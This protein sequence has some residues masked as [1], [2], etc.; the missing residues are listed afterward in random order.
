M[1]ESCIK[2]G[3][4]IE[5]TLEELDADGEWT[6]LPHFGVINDSK[7]T[8]V[9]MVITGD[10][11]DAGRYSTNDWLL[12]GP[13]VILLIPTTLTHIRAK[14]QF[15]VTDISKAFFQIQLSEEDRKLLVFL[16]LVKQPGGS[17]LH[18]F[19]RF[20]K[21]PLGISCSP[22][23]LN[24][25]LR[26]LFREHAEKY[27]EDKPLMQEFEDC[28]YL[29]EVAITREEDQ[30]T[31]GKTQ[32]LKNVVA[33]AFFRVTKFKSYPPR[34]T[35]EFCLE[36]K[37]KP[38]KILGL[39]FNPVDDCF[40]IKAR[41]LQEFRHKKLIT[42]K[43]AASILARPFDPLGF[44]TWALLK[45]KLLRQK[46]DVNHPKADWKHHLTQEETDQWH[47]LTDELSELHLMKIPQLMR[48]KNKV[49]REYHIF[50]DAS[51]LA[52]GAAIYC[53]S[54]PKTGTPEVT[55]IAAK[56]KI[57]PTVKPSENFKTNFPETNTVSI[58]KLNQ[59]VPYSGS[60]SSR[61]SVLH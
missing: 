14:N 4:V 56:S 44:A 22:F 51:G 38:F 2:H 55:L 3:V 26:K 29:D 43:E 1:F 33:D 41:N 10:A 25:A 17:Y 47:L 20:E 42:K 46:I 37:N 36:E 53:V 11:K 16:W 15:M 57:I 31:V 12:K 58:N 61:Q 35:K 13:N 48:A 32:K 34:L 60:S 8:P 19:Y 7:T 52:I 18:K 59:M 27:P 21:M 30:E 23:V 6:E 45:A 5:K 40:F 49:R 39:G 9:R 50:T 28:A 24:T 54:Y